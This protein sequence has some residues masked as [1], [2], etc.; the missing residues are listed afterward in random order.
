MELSEFLEVD[1]ENEGGAEEREGKD[2]QGKIEKVDGGG[3]GKEKSEE[4]PAPNAT[5]A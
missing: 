5:A 3:E 4:N 2:D 1:G